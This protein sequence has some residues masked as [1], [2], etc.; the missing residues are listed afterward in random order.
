M[1]RKKSAINEGKTYSTE[2]KIFLD[3]V[4]GEPA[5]RVRL[6]T[7]FLGKGYK[8]EKYT[9]KSQKEAEAFVSQKIQEKQGLYVEA[10]SLK[11][12]E[13]L[14]DEAKVVQQLLGKKVSLLEVVNAWKK[15]IEPFL[16][17]PLVKNAILELV[18]FKKAQ[19]QSER[20]T[21]E[22]KA[23]LQRIF[24]GLENRKLADITPQDM[25]KAVRANDATGKPP[26]FSQKLKRMRYSTILFNW[27]I[28]KGYCSVVPLSGVARPQLTPKAPT[29]LSASDVK[30]L[31]YACYQ[32]CPEAVPALTIKLFAGLRNSE[33]YKLDWKQISKSNIGITALVSKTNKA[34]SITIDPILENWF[35]NTPNLVRKRLVFN[36]SPK[37]NDREAV[38]LKVLNLL[39]MKSGVDITQNVLR[40]TFGSYFYHRSKSAEQTA[41]EMGNSSRVV[42]NNYVDAV[43][44]EECESFWSVSPYKLLLIKEGIELVED[45]S[46]EEQARESLKDKKAVITD[47]IKL[48]SAIGKKLI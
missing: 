8:A 9:F 38:W 45:T 19:N 20:H 24:R 39:K 22:L 37:V 43:S 18:E 13:K 7:R 33:I 28:E 26:S 36:M 35:K 29:P 10:H 47:I 31:L 11:V 44:D 42:L 6:G 17:S 5:W 4:N 32:N 46:A 48:Q 21:R 1:P 30:N 34:R 15:Q 23:K 41:F 40:H 3:T 2:P 25:E 14:L 27:G 12:P 16:G